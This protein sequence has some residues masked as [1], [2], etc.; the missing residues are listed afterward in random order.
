MGTLESG[1]EPALADETEG[2]G[3]AGEK[4]RLYEEVTTY[5]EGS[6]AE[7]EDEIAELEQLLASTPGNH[8][9]EEWLAFKYYST[10]RFEKA[11][12][13][14][15]GLIE[16]GHRIGVQHFYLGNTYFKMQRP[17]KAREAWQKTIELIPTDAKAQK[18]RARLARLARLDRDGAE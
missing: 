7:V 1:R 11:I 4:R 13:L 10:G 17:T 14:Y 3:R 18:A 5:G 6:N 16:A 12:Q 2:R 15:K 8:D 9:I